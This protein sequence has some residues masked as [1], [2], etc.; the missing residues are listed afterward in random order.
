MLRESG[1]R[2]KGL[3]FQSFGSITLGFASGVKIFYPL[4][5]LSFISATEKRL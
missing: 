4:M 3:K 2:R 5:I 1:V